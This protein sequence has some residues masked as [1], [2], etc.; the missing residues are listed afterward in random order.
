[1]SDFAWSSI[2]SEVLS[3]RLR[4]VSR[5]L[6][7]G[8]VPEDARKV[9]SPYGVDRADD[10]YRANDDFT[11]AMEQLHPADKTLGELMAE[12]DGIDKKLNWYEDIA[13]GFGGVTIIGCAVG[14]VGLGLFLSGPTV[15]GEVVGLGGTALALGAGALWAS[16]TVKINAQACSSTFRKELESWGAELT[17]QRTEHHHLIAALSLDEKRALLHDLESSR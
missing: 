1:M 4:V 9:Y 15:A 13:P 3:Q 17:R 2:S 16:F 5:R 7:A 6:Q 14:V 10:V 8:E 12:A 11:R